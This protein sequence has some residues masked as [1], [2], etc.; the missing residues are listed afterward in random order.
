M[1]KESPKTE[2]RGCE[3]CRVVFIGQPGEALCPNCTNAISRSK[4]RR[5]LIAAQKQL[6]NPV[7]ECLIKRDGDTV[8]HVGGCQ[9]RFSQNDAGHSVCNVTNYNHN[10]F[11]VKSGHY[12][13]Y[14]VG[15]P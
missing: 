5:A 1:S 7:L 15:E 11:L 14:V 2:H 12:R 3:R 4:K 9:Y 10:K 13:P 6:L 8:V